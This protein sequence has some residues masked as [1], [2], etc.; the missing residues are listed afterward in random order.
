MAKETKAR[1]RRKTKLT[2]PGK[3]KQPK[4]KLAPLVKGI[5]VISTISISQQLK[6]IF[7][8]GVN[9]PSVVFKYKHLASY[10]DSKIRRK[11]RRFNNDN[12]IGLIVTV[13]GLKA[14]D[15]AVSYAEKPFVSLVGAEPTR[16]PAKA[17]GGV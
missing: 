10:K 9:D 4:A 6:D 8:I 7:E 12:D 2:S 11:F 15:G 5:G 16:F 14:Y 13:G 1:T 3:K 17:R